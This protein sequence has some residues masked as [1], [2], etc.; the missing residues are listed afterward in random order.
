MLELADMSLVQYPAEEGS[1]PCY[2]LVFLLA[3]GK[4][5]QT[6][7]KQFM[8]AMRHK[9]PTLCT[10]GA[11]A[12]YL[13]WRWHIGGEEPPS[14]RS[15]EDWYRIKML[16]ARDRSIS[17]SYATQLED[18]WRAFEGAGILSQKKTHAMRG[19][20]AR[21]AE[22]H[23]ISEGQVGSP[24]LLFFLVYKARYILFCPVL[25][26]SVLFCFVLV[27]SPPLFSSPRF[28][29]YLTKVTIRL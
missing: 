18:V 13:F 8:G 11:L 5:N 24:S 1:T 22:L 23:G 2:A 16:V 10:M 6:G 19:C 20:G 27:F 25:S 26:Y 15:R 9:D 4:T 28:T 17:I 14:F 29:I 7:K 3:N 12:Q 21:D